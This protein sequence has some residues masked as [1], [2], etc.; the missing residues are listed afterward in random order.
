[1]TGS[2]V[3]SLPGARIANTLRHKA[4]LHGQYLG[5]THYLCTYVGQRFH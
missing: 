3:E 5:M 1:M 2:V 4:P